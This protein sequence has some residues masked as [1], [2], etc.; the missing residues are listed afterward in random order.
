MPPHPSV[1]P[2]LIAL[3]AL[4]SLSACGDGT[5]VEFCG[6]SAPGVTVS[7]DNCNPYIRFG[8]GS[9]PAPSPAPAASSPAPAP[10]R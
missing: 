5:T 1:P 8:S 2:R 10:R 4:V 7:T 9:P 3:F 6:S